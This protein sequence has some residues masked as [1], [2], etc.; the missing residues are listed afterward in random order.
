MK[1]LFPASVLLVGLA[2]GYWMGGTSNDSAAASTGLTGRSTSTDSSGSETGT[3]A[4]LESK[5]T[6]RMAA[7]RGELSEAWFESLQSQEQLDQLAALIPKIKSA[8]PVDFAALMNAITNYGGNME[9]MTRDLLAT[10]WA[11]TDPQGMIRYI[12]TLPRDQRSAL[13]RTFY[14]VWAH[15]APEAAFASA[16]SIED[17]RERSRAMQSVVD[18]I[19][20]TQPR[21]AVEM[22][23]SMEAESGQNASWMLRNIFRTWANNDPEAARHAAL[24][25]PEGQSKVRAL[26]GA[27][28]EWM[29]DDPVGAL[30]WLD[31]LPADGT[32][33]NSRKE[34]F[35]QFL[36]SNFDTAKAFIAQRSDP[37]ERREVLSS[38]YFGNFAWRME[39]EE[40]E[41]VYEWL[42]EV[43]SGETYDRKVSDLIQS[44]VNAD[45]GRAI[46]FAMNLPP[47][48]A[49]MNALA[50]LGSK[51]AQQDPA[52]AIALAENMVYDDE[53]DRV[54]RH[55][56]WQISRY[57]AEQAAELVAASPDAAVQK[58]LAQQITGEWS[59]YDRAGAL[60]WAESLEDDQVRND[61]LRPVFGNWIQAD[62]QGALDYLQN[63]VEEGKQQNY[64]SNAF[65]QWT[66]Q[67]PEDA[68]SWLARLPESFSDARPNIYGQVASAYVRHDPM[69]A[70]EWI[71]SLDDGPE[72]DRS[73]E[74]LVNSI[75]RNDPEAGFLWAATVK[76]K[77]RR[78]NTLNRSVREWVKTDPEA[79]YEAVRKANIEAEEKEPLF[80]MIE[81]EQDG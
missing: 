80:Q 39:F 55:M 23:Q 41:G 42:G 47:G 5:Q 8:S 31:S 61:A 4:E 34:V 73:V 16:S 67:A 56:A 72:R 37:L 60:A 22:A 62:P 10:R 24:A 19:A 25:L 27:L 52:M 70:S 32:V 18:T 29:A 50:Q 81:Q 13:S 7:E 57:G 75:S 68:V 36:S 76:D 15:D 49:R 74:T 54:L 12:G 63:S 9:R 6:G 46:D 48:N 78:S 30:N 51:L 66:R 17:R 28:G 20:E 58:G 2:A 64:L 26:S 65:S 45:P 44:M 69:A 38:M 3:T 1:G 71:A 43:S 77:G 14:N 53:K 59:K 40:I 33:Y 35:R 11:K 21:R 79:A